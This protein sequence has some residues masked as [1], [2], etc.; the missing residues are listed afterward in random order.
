MELAVIKILE[1]M[2]SSPFDNGIERDKDTGA[3]D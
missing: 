3:N 1:L 2:T